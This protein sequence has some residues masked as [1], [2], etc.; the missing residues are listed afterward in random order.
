VLSSTTCGPEI[1]VPNDHRTVGVDADMI[2]YVTVDN[3]SPANYVSYSGACE[4]QGNGLNNVLAGR[5]VL[6][7]PNIIAKNLLYNL[8]F[9]YS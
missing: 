1:N 9:F 8:A 2:I 5:I 6:N 4:I 7:R 3:V